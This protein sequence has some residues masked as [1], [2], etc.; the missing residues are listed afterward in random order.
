MSASTYHVE[1]QYDDAP[2]QRDAAMLGMWAFIATE[3]LFFS[4]LFAGY[5]ICRWRFPVAFQQGSGHTNLVMGSIETA[6]LLVSGC[7]AALGLRA[8]Q[9]D[10]RRQASWLLLL[11]AAL[12]LAFLVMHGFE[13]REE[14]REGLIPGVRFLQAGPN[15]SSMELFFCLYYVITGFH[16]LHVAIGVLL[17]AEMARRIHA[18]RYASDYYT[19][20]E[21]AAL[22][23]SLVDVVWIFVFPVIYL[24][25]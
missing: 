11:T 9:L 7:M 21:I 3:V 12:G 1:E 14:Y 2:Q 8:V 20:I 24:G 19:P 4:V 10:Q 15:A 13:Y 18:G 5:A 17:L 23:W 22:Y 16:T 25:R 6:V